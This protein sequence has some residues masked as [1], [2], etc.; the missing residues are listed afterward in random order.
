MVS[1]R[2]GRDTE[3]LDFLCDVLN[4]SALAMSVLFRGF[5]FN[6]I[7]RA[8]GF[9]NHSQTSK[10]MSGQSSSTVC[11]TVGTKSRS[12]CYSNEPSYNNSELEQ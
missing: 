5:R 2:C 7:S 4:S 11:A 6:M 8:V 12:G 10:I 1:Y 9:D 3:Q